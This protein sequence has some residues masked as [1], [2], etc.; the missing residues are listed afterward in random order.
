MVLLFVGWT[1]GFEGLL[2]TFDSRLPSRTEIHVLS[3]APLS[4]R[5]TQMEAE[6]LNLDGTA[7]EVEGKSGKVS[8]PG[9]LNGVVS[10]YTGF[11]TDMN[12]MRKLPIDRA[13]AV[14]VVADTNPN[15][16]TSG[17]GGSDLQIADSECLTSTILLRRLHT[18]LAKSMVASGKPPPPPL[19][20]VTQFEDLLTRRLLERQPD[21]LDS[22]P[23]DE[24]ATAPPNPQP[25]SV[26]SSVQD[27]E[28]LPQARSKPNEVE[29]VGFHRN[30]IETTC[31]SLAAQSSACWTAISVLLD[32]DGPVR[33][34][35][36]KVTL[37]LRSGEMSKYL[38]TMQKPPMLTGH[39][40]KSHCQ[41]PQQ[42]QSSSD[43]VKLSFWTL[44]ER[45]RVDLDNAL[46]VG[47]RRLA[48]KNDVVLN[49]PDKE[50]GLHW[51]SKDKLIVIQPR[52]HVETPRR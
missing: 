5:E 15:D 9:L 4:W 25:S 3:E 23:A 28:E 7:V 48:E 2:R 10:Q 42:Q 17:N 43:G 32:P 50:A 37:L 33:L 30:Y 14:V 47:W 52:T 19:T 36:V 34:K 26:N 46:L 29:T 38:S 12:A 1:R 49:P 20:L 45:V 44:A 16:A 6:G 22:E 31:L 51:C 21:L 24:D 41:S 8:N 40:R 11:T 27:D 35:T 39:A 18:E 13:N